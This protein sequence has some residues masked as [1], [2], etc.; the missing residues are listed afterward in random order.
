MW[1]ACSRRYCG[2]RQRSDSGGW[3]FQTQG[4][5]T[6]C[7]YLFRPGSR[8][9]RVGLGITIPIGLALGWEVAVRLGVSDGRL[10]PPPS[11]ILTTLEELGTS[12][13]LE[14]HMLATLTRVAVGFVLGVGCGTVLA[15][16]AGYS[17]I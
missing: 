11:T 14:R 5:L 7:R 15:A 9:V 8:P 2:S 16:L 4:S 17:K 13:E 12:G 1:G 6:A 10:V 3:H